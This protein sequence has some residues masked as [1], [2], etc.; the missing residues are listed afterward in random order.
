VRRIAWQGLEAQTMKWSW[1][2]GEFAGIGVYIHATFLL[3][4]ALVGVVAWLQ[5]RSAAGVADGVAFIVAIFVCVVLHEYGH[6]LAARRYGIPTRDITLYPIGGVSRLERMPEEPHEEML[7]ALSGPSVNILVG[8]VLF[9]WLQ[10]TGGMPALSG[11]GIIGGPF[12]PRLMVV[13]LWLAAFNLIPAFPM[14]GGRVLRALLAMRTDYVR[15]THGA[16]AVGQALALVFGF[17][18]FFTNPLLIFIAL[19][20]WIGASQEASMTQLQNALGGIPVARTMVTDFQAVS[21]EQPLSAVVELILRGSQVDF[22]VLEAGQL[23]GVLR[24]DDLIR[25][26][27]QKGDS[28]PVSSVMRR[29]FQTAEASEML[30]VAFS[31]LHD[32][33]CHTLPVLQRGQLVGLLTEDNVGEFLMIQAARGHRSSGANARA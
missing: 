9:A 13:N 5:A 2:I 1:K 27:A 32:C 17:I 29:D 12:L 24:R 18:G 22:P 21:A 19:F 3:L 11:L 30:E 7:V 31:R 8:V 28:A 23:A 14:D 15:A 16:A 6:A 33:D 26:L 4:L 25:A 10:V 20:V